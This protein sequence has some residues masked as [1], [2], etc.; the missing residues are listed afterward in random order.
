[1]TGKQLV[2]N[3]WWKCI[4]RFFTRCNFLSSHSQ[5]NSQSPEIDRICKLIN[6][7]PFPHFAIE[8]TLHHSNLTLSDSLVENVLGRLFS[9]HVNGSKALQ[10]FHWIARQNPDYQHTSQ[11][12]EK[13]LHILARMR[14]FNE[15]WELLDEMHQQNK[16]TLKALSVVL[17]KYARR[18]SFDET[19]E[20]FEKMEKFVGKLNTD[21]FNVLLQAFC[22]QRHVKEARAVF[23]KMHHRFAPNA[24]TFNILLLGFKESGN[25]VATEIF[26]REMIRR[27]FSPNIVTYNIL[28]D[29]LCKGSRVHDALELLEVMKKN[30][31]CPDIRT[32]TTLIHGLGIVR[33]IDRARKLFDEMI[34]NGHGPDTTAYNALIS[35]FCKSGRVK[36]GLILMKEMEEKGVGCD[37]MTYHTILYAFQELQNEEEVCELFVRMISQDWVPRVSTAVMLMK[38]F[39]SSGLH[40]MAIKLWNYVIKKGSCPHGHVSNM[41]ITELC[42]SGKLHE[43]YSCFKEILEKGLHPYRQSVTVLQRFFKESR[44]V[45]QLSELT[46]MM[47]QIQSC[48]PASK[49]YISD[50]STSEDKHYST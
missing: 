37:N 33:D 47:K 36:D 5:I 2:S 16:I 32:Y 21:T 26:F 27:G 4:P 25:A 23:N 44:R 45:E 3:A 1:M 9:G 30:H 46:E 8:S 43:A 10:F 35:C 38:F 50:V 34:I 14:D 39:C 40:D 49:E 22:T 13:M 6:D 18:R 42:Y 11:A 28:I 29:A 20:A 31:C 48:L 19:L 17:S 7:H 41:L 12:Y 24:Q 15:V